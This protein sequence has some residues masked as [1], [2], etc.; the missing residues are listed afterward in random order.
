MQHETGGLPIP[1]AAGMA[2]QVLNALAAA[3]QQ[4]YVH[5]DVKPSN[6]LVELREGGA[7][8]AWLADFGLAR[9]YQSSRLSGLTLTGT[10]GGTTP[11]MPPEQITDYRHVGPAADQYSVA[12]TLYY[13]LTKQYAYDLPPRDVPKQL[14]MILQQPPVPIEQRRADLPPA[15]MAA[16]HR[17]LARSP[18]DR[19]ADAV[20]FRQALQAACPC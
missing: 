17:A 12:A 14:L 8:H 5:R 10:V 16:I 1:R 18:A 7:E 11:F 4:G 2:C 20:A 15:L 6:I 9:V 3:H 19:F 13:L